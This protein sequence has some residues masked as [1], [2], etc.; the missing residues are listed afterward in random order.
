MVELFKDTVEH[1]L[2]HKLERTDRHLA[3][4]LYSESLGA[5]TS[6]EHETTG[7]KQENTCMKQDS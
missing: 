1:E 7:T 5:G 3:S 4:Y 2:E 6:T